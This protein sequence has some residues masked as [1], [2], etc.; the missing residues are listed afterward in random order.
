MVN[1]LLSQYNFNEEWAR[2]TMRKYINCNDKVAIIP[3]SFGKGISNDMDWQNMYNKNNGKYY[4]ETVGPFVDLG[5]SEENII[6]INYFQHTVEEMKKIIESSD[7]LFLTGGDT[8]NAVERVLEKGLLH[9][10]EKGKV[11]IGSS[12]GALMQLK[13]YYISTDEGNPEFKYCEGLGLIK[14][15]FYI[16]VHYEDN[17]IQN[18]CIERVLKEKTDSIY[19]I[20]NTGGIVLDE[21]EITL[22]GDVVTFNR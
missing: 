7:I 13:N 22:M 9:S 10:I 11:I 19:A 5:I 12:A 3:F 17:H 6:W 21:D 18:K 4:R 1:I 14:K 20:K 15:N 2:D 8:E 16:E